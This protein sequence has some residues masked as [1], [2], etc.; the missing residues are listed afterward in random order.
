MKNGTINDDKLEKAFGLLGLEATEANPF[1][2]KAKSD[3]EEDESDE[4]EVDEDSKKI[5][6]KIQNE[7]YS[8]K[9]VEKGGDSEELD[10]ANLD[11]NE[12]IEKAKEIA[13]LGDSKGLYLAFSKEIMKAKAQNTIENRALG[14]LVKAVLDENQVLKGHV[15]SQLE[16]F[17]N[18][19]QLIEE[20]NEII[21]GFMEKFEQFGATPTPRKSI[22]KGF[23]ERFEEKPEQVIEK[24]RQNGNVMSIS[25]DKSRILD[26]LD[27]KTFDKGFNDIMSKACISFEASGELGADT[28]RILK[29]ENGIIITQ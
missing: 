18:Q 28:I 24:A 5:A 12:K 2:Q 6:D 7:N 20:Q 11:K 19:S 29:E 13:S 27:K 10:S 21:K 9:K 17:N 4:E 16:A 3:D 26:V 14:I 8:E 1:L 15:E 23:A 25:R 22:V